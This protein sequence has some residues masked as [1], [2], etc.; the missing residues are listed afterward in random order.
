MQIDYALIHEGSNETCIRNLIKVRENF[1]LHIQTY[2]T[3]KLS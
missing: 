1:G 3:P 2:D